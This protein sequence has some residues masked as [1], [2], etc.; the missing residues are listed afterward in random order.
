MCLQS[1]IPAELADY[2]VI[3]FMKLHLKD[4]DLENEVIPMLKSVDFTDAML[5]GA[6]Y[7]LSGGWR[8]KLA[9]GHAILRG[10][11]I[12]LLDEPTNHLDVRNVAWVGTT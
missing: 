2:N 7:R 4:K 6:V 3:D 5:K 9:L 1:E 10:A 12:L 8:M 11:D